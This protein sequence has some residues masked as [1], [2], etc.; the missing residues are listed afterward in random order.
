[1]PR[2]GANIQSATPSLPHEPSFTIR[3]FGEGRNTHWADVVNLEDLTA[4]QITPEISAI[5]QSFPE[6]Y[7]L[8]ESKS[9]AQRIIGNAVPP[10]LAKALGTALIESKAV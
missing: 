2:C 3:A 8:P 10:L 5:L 9:L 1:M 4:K 7:L 6:S